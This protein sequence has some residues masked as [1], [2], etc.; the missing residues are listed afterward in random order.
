LNIVFA[1]LLADILSYLIDKI[2]DLFIKDFLQFIE[3]IFS[4]FKVL[5]YFTVLMVTSP[6][7]YLLKSDFS[8]FLMVIYWITLQLLLKISVYLNLIFL[9]NHHSLN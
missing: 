3:K 9:F 5:E 8:D 7:G 6:Y 2:I 4:K 1:D